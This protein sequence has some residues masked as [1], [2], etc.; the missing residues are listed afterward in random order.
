MST[1][2]VKIGITHNDILG[3]LC[4]TMLI[5]DYGKKFVIDESET[6]EQFMSSVDESK[7]DETEIEALE[8]I[9]ERTSE[10]KVITFLNDKVTDLQAGI[11]LSEKRKKIYVVFRGSESVY[12]WLYDMQVGKVEL[13]DGVEVH[14]GFY[15]QLFDGGSYAILRDEILLLLAKEEYSDFEVFVTGHSL[16][17]NLC[18]LFGYFLSN[19]IKNNII[20]VTFASPRT[21][22]KVFVESINS[23]EN[24]VHYRVTTEKDIVTSLPYYNYYH[25]GINIRLCEDDV[26]IY[27]NDPSKE[28]NIFTC[29]SVSDHYCESYYN[30]LKKLKW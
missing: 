4:L 30:K 15:R 20:A 5:Y 17:S 11:T 2:Q 6:L 24:M 25:S 28:Y 12:D 13:G 21:G 7:L 14:K 23:K 27:K 1:P 29:Y 22:N 10:G 18:L 3:L 16:G 19:E 26:E 9:C 8:T